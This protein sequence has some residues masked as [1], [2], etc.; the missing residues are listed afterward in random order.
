VK[1]ALRDVRDVADWGGRRRTSTDWGA[2]KREPKTGFETDTGPGG[3]GGYC[4]WT[5]YC[6]VSV[7]HTLTPNST[8]FG[9]PTPAW[10]NDRSG[11]GGIECFSY[12][13]KKL[14]L[15]ATNPWAVIKPTGGWLPVGHGP[16]SSRLWAGPSTTWLDPPDPLWPKILSSEIWEFGTEP[17]TMAKWKMTLLIKHLWA[18]QVFHRIHKMR[19]FSECK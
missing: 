16:W 18:G 12:W 14:A 8:P 13:R 5:H 4:P 15:R 10:P 19:S 1:F 7:G 17:V 9:Q 6:K 2:A 3:S 11:V